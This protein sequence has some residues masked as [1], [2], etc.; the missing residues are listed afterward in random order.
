ME[1]PTFSRRKNFSD[2]SNSYKFIQYADKNGSFSE[3]NTLDM[4]NTIVYQKFII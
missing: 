1:K 2:F 4:L 3:Q